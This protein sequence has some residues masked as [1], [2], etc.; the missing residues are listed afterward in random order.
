[1]DERPRSGLFREGDDGSWFVSFLD[2]DL[3]YIEKNGSQ[4]LFHPASPANSNV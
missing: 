1:L 4:T 2:L 3:G